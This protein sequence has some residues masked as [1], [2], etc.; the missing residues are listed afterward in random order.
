MTA[1]DKLDDIG[2]T[3][4]EI[5]VALIQCSGNL[6]KIIVNKEIYLQKQAR[7]QH[8]NPRPSCLPP[9]H[10]NGSVLTQVTAQEGRRLNSPLW[11]FTALPS[12]WRHSKH[13][14]TN[15]YLSLLAKANHQPHKLTPSLSAS[16]LHTLE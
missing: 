15:M 13:L 9:Q 1:G 2:E 11:V 3:Q 16:L 10:Q 14:Q 8:H 6:F 5:Y 7:R 4:S 12:S